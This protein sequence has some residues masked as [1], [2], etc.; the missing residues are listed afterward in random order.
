MWTFKFNFNKEYKNSTALAMLITT[1]YNE[2]IA[3]ETDYIMIT[4]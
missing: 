3:A 4:L 1:D 2:R